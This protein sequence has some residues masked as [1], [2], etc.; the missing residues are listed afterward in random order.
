MLS[1]AS[2]SDPDLGRQLKNAANHIENIRLA[3]KIKDYP[4]EFNFFQAWCSKDPINARL[5]YES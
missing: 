5:Y 3:L 1:N 2:F 4:K